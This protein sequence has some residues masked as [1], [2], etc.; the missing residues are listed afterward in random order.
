MRQHPEW[1]HLQYYWF[2][3][4]KFNDVPKDLNDKCIAEVITRVEG[5]DG[6]SVGIIAAQDIIDIVL[7]HYGPGIYNSA[8]RDTKKLLETKLSDI[9]FEIDQLEQA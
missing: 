7:E 4:K 5:I 6:D 1:L 9:E 8:L 2:M 3:H